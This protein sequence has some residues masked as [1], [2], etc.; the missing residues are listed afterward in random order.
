MRGLAYMHG[1]RGRKR[2]YI[3][4][5]RNR[6]NPLYCDNGFASLFDPTKWKEI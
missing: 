2:M 5:K 6:R 3:D 1:G 4:R